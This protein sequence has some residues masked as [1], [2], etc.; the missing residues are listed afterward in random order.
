MSKGY[1]SRR[2][3]VD[4]AVP[5]ITNVKCA[6]L[7]IEALVRKPSFAIDPVDCKSSHRTVTLPGLIAL[8]AFVPGL[9]ESSS[10]DIANATDAALRGGFT[11]VQL[12][13]MGITDAAKFRISQTKASKLSS[14]DFALSVSATDRNAEEIASSLDITAQALLVPYHNISGSGSVIESVASVAAHFESWPA[15]RPLVTDAKRTELASILLL[16]NLHNRSIHVTG[17]STKED[18]E[19]IALVKARDMKVTC[20][21]A[22][23]SL[24]FAQEDFPGATSLPTKTDVNALW[25]SMPIIDAFSIGSLPYEM[26]RDLGRPYNAAAG[27]E[28]ALPLLLSAVA[29]GRLT[30]ADIVTR[31][32]DNPRTIF[33]LAEQADT[34]VDIEADRSAALSAQSQWS[35]LAHQILTGSVHRVVVRGETS[36]LDGKTVSVPGSAVDLGNFGVQTI[37]RKKSARFSMTGPRPSLQSAYSGSSFNAPKS[38]KD[39][40][41]ASQITK[42][43]TLRGASDHPTS[44]RLQPSAFSLNAP[45]PAISTPLSSFPVELSFARR[46][47]L[48]IKQ[49]TREDMHL[50]FSIANE[51]RVQVERNSA[52]HLLDGHVLCNLFFEPSTRT[53]TS[54]DAAMLRLGGRVATVPVNKSSITKGETLADTIRTVA[55]Y[56]DAIVL[57]HPDV[58][59]SQLAAKFSPVPI[60]NAGDGTGEHP[61]QAMLDV[62]TIREELG[63]VNGL[64]VTG[65]FPSPVPS[66]TH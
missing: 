56:S 60:I 9:A 40:N 50:L 48:S 36:Y 61:T 63:T 52:I 41:F 47:V 25:K 12:S 24:F 32:A 19:L 49:Y 66:V 42:S 18:I 51:M 20:D 10:Q 55:S 38:P 29:D 62:Y 31:L 37:P 33:D 8:N 46:H 59:S 22:I 6:K 15:E 1:R 4:F 43:P 65:A 57:R 27:Y 2:M 5:L 64:T 16:S 58:G 7:F 26:A 39:S 3:A 21:V 53:S 54:F 30:I 23:Y 11:A 14:C 13:S 44:N 45:A 17:V 35:P 28:E 34:Y